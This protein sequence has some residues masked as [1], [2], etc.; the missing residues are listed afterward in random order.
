MAETLFV[1]ACLPESKPQSNLYHTLTLA[2][3]NASA[4]DDIVR[5][6]FES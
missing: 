3:A 1:D 2:V 4:G 5:L 6:I